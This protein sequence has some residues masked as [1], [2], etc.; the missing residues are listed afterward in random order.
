MRRQSRYRVRAARPAKYPSARGWLKP[1]AATQAWL[2][3]SEE[4]AA[5]VTGRYFRH[6]Q[7][8]PLLPPAGEVAVQ[9]G[10]LATC[11]RLSGAAIHD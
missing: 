9:D 8:L 6:M 7:R 4:P 10:L 2:A 5:Q 11:E 3:S 1:A